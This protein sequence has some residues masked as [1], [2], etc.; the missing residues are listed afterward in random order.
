MKLGSHDQA[1]GGGAASD[2]PVVI[3]SAAA[4][5]AAT[6]WLMVRVGYGLDFTDE[7]QYYGEIASLVRTG[8]FFQDDL[9]TQQL[10]YLF[11]WPWFK[12]HAFI[13]PQQD[14]LIVWGRLLMVTSYGVVGG[15]LWRT[16][17]RMRRYSFAQRLSATAAFLAWVP[18]Q[19]LAP[20]YNS[21]A[22]LLAV[23]GLTIWLKNHVDNSDEKPWSLP[24]L[25]GALTA[26]YPPAGIALVLL[27]S[28]DTASRRGRAAALQQAGFFLA[29]GGLLLA[30]VCASHGSSFFHDLV[31]ALRFSRAFGVGRTL[32]QAREL[33]L[34]CGLITASFVLSWLRRSWTTAPDL[35]LE[36]KSPSLNNWLA[37]LAA[38]VFGV[39]LPR[40]S[41]SLGTGPFASLVFLFLLPLAD[42]KDVMATK[43]AVVGVVLG[44][45]FAF[46]SSNGAQ[47]FGI[48]AAAILPFLALHAG[49]R[50]QAPRTK[51]ARR[52]SPALIAASAGWLLL[53]N[54]TA[55]PYRESA[56]WLRF[57]PVT[58]VP[59]FRGLRTS[60][61][62]LEVLKLFSGICLPGALRGK[63]V[64]VAG[65]HPA[66]YFYSAGQ[67][68]TSMFF[69]HSTGQPQAYRLAAERLFQNGEPHCV[70]LVDQPPLE[71]NA[72]IVSWAK[73]GCT[74]NSVR[75]P[76]S[77]NREYFE[78]VGY[79]FSPEIVLLTRT[80]TP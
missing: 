17:G 60:A 55:H 64:L 16:T 26:I 33:G 10:G 27:A 80:E 32:L 15:L 19:L 24:L 23:A 44:S 62:K 6:L 25:L 47:N 74:V 65:P 39:F 48:G 59:A 11:V 34:C 68:S 57:E 66:F 67:P 12:L 41:S 77:L 54:G 29:V 75:V 49:G 53:C 73:T 45:V 51:G 30:I 3:L 52:L 56:G 72:S 28:R 31:F 76:P 70:L 7:L 46:T 5:V 43:F 22:F 79:D 63:R 50:A 61:V 13:F 9:F 36:N 4:V 18:F 21:L 69:L 40:M 71:I 78:M 2:R 14:Y 38:G 20:S 37:W 1:S 42:R 8:R 58:T 35:D